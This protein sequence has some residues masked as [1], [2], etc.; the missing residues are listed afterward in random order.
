GPVLIPTLR[1]DDRGEISAVLTA[2]GRAFAHGLTINWPTF[3]PTTTTTTEGTSDAPA[4]TPVDLPTYA[5][6]HQRYWPRFTGLPAGDLGSAGL[7]SAQHPL[8][9][10]A[11]S[12]AGSADGSDGFDGAYGSAEGD[13]V[14][15][16]GR[17]SVAAQPWL[18]EH[19]V[20][21][22]VLLPGTAFLELAVRAGDQVGCA[23]VEE[24]TLQAPLVLP[25]RG[26]VQLQVAVGAADETGRRTLS[27]Y[28]R[29]QDARADQPWVRHAVGV[30]GTDGAAPGAGLSQWPPA[31]AEPVSVEGLYEGLTSAGF[32]YGPLFRG[33]RQVWSRGDELFA[34]VELP[35]RAVPEAA[36][37][38][39]HPA[40]LD[41]VLHALGLVESGRTDED[42]AEAGQGRLPFSWSGATLHASGASVLRARLTVRGPDSVALELADASGA[43]VATIDSLVLRPVS[44]D[45]IAQ[46]KAGGQ[47]TALHTM[48]WIP[49]PEPATTDA[50]TQP[51]I[52]IEA[53]VD[54]CEGAE[55]RPDLS[56]IGA[57]VYPDLASLPQDEVPSHVLLRLDAPD[58]DPAAAAHTATHRALALLQ[59]WLADERFAAARLVVVTEGA[60]TVDERRPDPALAAVWGLVRSARSEHPDRFTLVDLDAASESLATL[61]AALAHDEPELA[62][63]AGQVYVPRLSRHVRPDALPVPELSEAWCLDIAEKGTLANLRLTESPTA[64]AELGVGEVRI[65][66]R[67]AG[68]NFRDVLNALGMYPGDAVALGIEGAGVVTE[69]GPGV[70]GLA[71]GDR[72]MGLFTQSFGPRAVA[73]ARTLARIPEGW[74]FAQAASVPVVFLTAYYALVDLGELQA[75][76]SVLVHAAAGG[77]G[78][79][80]VQLARHLGAEVF[81]TASPG[82]WETLRSSGLDAAHIASSRELDFERSF[83]ETTGGRGVDVVLD[84]L[85]REFVD[86][87]LR[88]LP[89][90]GRF[91]EMGKT[92]VRDPGEVAA[93]HE[94]VRYR[95][96]DLFDAGPERIGEMLTALVALFEQDVLRPLPLTAWDVRKAPEAFRYLS[97]AKNVGKVVLTMP[98][99][100]DAE[101][102]VLV[103]GG[104]GG[105][106][107]LVARHLV[108][109]HGVRHLVLSSRRGPRAPGAAALRD[110]LAALGAEVTVA[111]CDTADREALRELLGSVPRR[112]PLTAIVHTAGVL[113][114]GVLSSLT[115]ERLDAVLVPK[116]DAVSALHEATRG[117]DLAAFVVFSSVAGMFGGSGQGNYSAANAFL[118]AFA[119]ARN[120][121][122]LPATA[123]A[124]GPWA[125]GAGMTGE[126]AEADLRRMARGGMV[127]FTAEQGMAAFDAA[128]R[129]AEA[130]YAP[131]RLD[132]AA[133]RAPQ[134]A[135]PA[136]L[137]ALVTGSARR[138]AASAAAGGA[139]ENLRTGLAALPPA[140]RE[141]AVLELVRAQAALVLGHAGS[142]AVEPAR[143]FRG[144]G[145]DSLTAVELRN[146]LGAATGL[147]LP[148]TLVFDYPSPTALARHVCTE[149]FGDDEAAAT[150]VAVTGRPVTGEEQLA[151]VAMS[152]RFPGGAGSPEEFWRLLADGVDALSPLPDDRG[153]QTGDDAAR[154]EGGFLYD[155]GDFDADFFGISPREAVTMDP[156]QRLLL[157]IS[158]ETLERAGIDP[159]ALRG[160]RTGVFAGTNY[161]GYGSAAH[162]LPEGAEGQLLTGH[163]TSV[164]SGRVSYALGLEGPAVT[165][166]T[167][168][169]SS[170]VALH[171][172]A[173]SL[174]LGECDLAL[175]GGVTVMATP[176]AFV[177]FGRQGGLAGDGRCK[178]FADDADGTGWGE[179]AGI[180]LVERLSDARRNGHPVLA[181]LRG[182][183]VNQDGA[184]N[185]LT[186][187][188]GPSQQRVI[189]AAL[190]N[191]GLDAHEVDAVEAHGTGTSL[192]DP[193]EAQA[194]IA[195]YGQDRAADRPLWLGS[196]KSNIGH[197]QA[198]AGIAGVIKMVLAL[199]K[200]VLPRTLHVTEPSSHVDWS[201]GEVRLLTRAVEWPRCELPRRAAVS[202]FGISGTN[203]HVV[204]EQYGA[205]DDG[206]EGAVERDGAA[207]ADAARAADAGADDPA[208]PVVWPL[209][210]RSG[211]AL[212]DQAKR[213]RAHLTDHPD[214]P[215]RDLGYSLATTRAAF[216]HR[217]ALVAEDR[218]AF[219]KGLAALARG[220]DTAELVRGRADTGGKLAFL[221]SG[222][223]SQRAGM[224]RELHARFPAYAAAFDEACAEFDRHLERPLREIVF[225]DEGTPEA[226]LLD[227][228][229][230]TQPALFAVET[231]LHALVTSWGIRPD[232]LIGHSIGELTAAHVAGVLTLADACRLVAARGRLMQ[233]LPE[234]GAMIAVQAAEEEVRPLLAGLA[235]RAGIAA[236]NGPTAVV[237]SGAQDAVTEIAAQLAERGRKTRRLRVSHAFHSPLM[238]TMLAEFGEIARGVRYAPPRVPVISNLTGEPAADADLTS[239]DYWVRH[240]REAVRF[241]DGVRRLEAD[242]VRTYLELGPDGALAAMA[243]ESLREPGEEAAALPVLRRDR[244]E[245]RSALLA[246]AHLHVR[247]L[248]AGPAALY[249][250]GAR[251]VELPTYAFQR[252]RYWLE[253]AGPQAGDGAAQSLD[254]QFWAAVEHTDPGE[255]AER[256]HLSGDAPL[257]DVL[258]ALSSWR[259]RQR[260]RSAADGWEYRVSWRPA[261]DAPAPVLSGTWLLVHPAGHADHAWEA[262]L[263]AGL[264]AHG[265]AAV[266]PVEV[267]CARADRKS[268]ADQLA[269]LL[270]ESGP[271]D[272]VL[273]LLGTDEEPHR[274]QPATPGGLAA[275]MALV[276]ALD[277]LGTGAPLWCATTGAVAVREGEAVPSPVQAAVWG[278]GRVAALEQPQSWGGLIDLPG[279]PDERAVARLCA[280]LEAGP[281]E[282]QIAVRGSG[283]FAR[284]LVRARTP[285]TA[286]GTD[287]PWA[288]TGTVLITGGTGALGA[289]LARRLADRGAA[290]LILAGRR[291]PQ[292][293]GA[294]ELRDELTARGTRV[295]LAA[296]DAADRDALARLLAEH[297]VDAVFHAAGVL[298]DG[299]LAGLDGDRLDA[300]LRSKMAAAAHLH[301]L[302]DGLSAFVLFS[303]FAGTAGATGQ[304][305]YAAANAYLDALAEHR[306]AL[307]LPATSVAWGPWAGAG[308]AAGGAGDEQLAERLTRGGMNTLDPR[309]A[310]DALERALTRGDTTLTVADV[311]WARFVPGFTSVRPSALLA[312]LPE[313]RRATPERE[314]ADGDGPGGLRALRA[315]LA[316]RSETDQERVLVTLVR[317]QVAG[318]LGY[319]AVDAIDP[320][321]AFSELGFDSLMAVELRNRLGL[322]T[323]TQLPATLLFDHPTAAALA[324]HLRTQVAAGD[325]AGALPALA[326]LDRLEDV[327]A[328]V[329]QDDPQRARI[330]SRLQTLLAK[331]S[332]RAEAD[333]AADDG[334]GVSDRINSA[335]ADEIFD[336]IDN[337]LGMS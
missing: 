134:S 323:G 132:H 52:S 248:G 114:D 227:R 291:G 211:A 271:V 12:L 59:A 55:A 123:L 288:C 196:V 207:P 109:A 206:P 190:A 241:C 228:T 229:A 49:L 264:T 333:T 43:P 152:C 183:A 187:P 23:Q 54:A 263:A 168:C 154:V 176:G 230:Y 232:V 124:W 309:L 112:H 13:A 217:A 65:A 101:G 95:A 141:P 231:A 90:G 94:G 115:P 26:A 169:S 319:D 80:A 279:E 144:L 99:P 200:G 125:P 4:L 249:G 78:M 29:P 198:A 106:G 287:E 335:T 242:G 281:G 327:L 153:W 318:V 102:T 46:A 289:H 91:L 307:G 180:V 310:V 272:G 266:V 40:L 214:L 179:G 88:L 136:L 182:S 235:D 308:M 47:D 131:V 225:A 269:T 218:D 185:G 111:A 159:A 224:G 221:F 270:G 83:L 113:D 8:L 258:P 72:V 155:S 117:E 201:A 158:W 107:A 33:L 265:A 57:T 195:T 164:T 118:D 93:A 301:E 297:P 2:A 138:S 166:D 178:A 298:D 285:D 294:T 104:T 267:D 21:G 246:A 193:I 148:A 53:A 160:S 203:A 194:L 149:L 110:E 11:V 219:L 67:A 37:F 234:G 122:G 306:H 92:D 282:D 197:T 51:P 10:A 76:E 139:A 143:D 276:Q 186:A 7:V 181:V 239:P 247:G 81:G 312:D 216:D 96:F 275:T 245:A 204:L 56:A 20:S 330:A 116:A 14:V 296:C 27:V 184:S 161:Q 244:P 337:D 274:G 3:F 157:E 205:A 325:S 305:N 62:V 262:A 16:T 70:T 150:S 129:T 15:F 126:L 292:A 250:E 39:L 121:V 172:A 226:A 28:S 120:G 286:P 58:G 284:R 66:V 177:E 316:G 259:H 98:V 257:R 50:S 25:E 5:F 240:V 100:L 103:T 213:L 87:S 332:E 174:R 38:G 236:V 173:Q 48:D 42:G 261:G 128:F 322:A 162:T 251:Q 321:R 202:S 69:V 171:L 283:V 336:F 209:S 199:R 237:V 233:A 208:G 82:K 243:W 75:G 163:A 260:E 313:A 268:L 165:V 22:S 334:A 156:Q 9:G 331:W 222:Q 41:S 191:A 89:R 86:A 71:P 303:S 35:E 63:R 295:T 278:L 252:R 189:R 24:L 210:A 329:A 192:G 85:A 74:S 315:Q 45:G 127:P 290:H 60:V 273:S 304:A 324:R 84:S 302:T 280:V 133:L 311:D 142:E 256:L 253:P 145:I 255:L 317:T 61:P 97:Q 223:G 188:N 175:A 326:E 6:Q 130:V 146:R 108:T 79:A 300:V 320:K 254:D 19:C 1:G 328:D 34:S 135:P 36:G 299:L 137:R 18:A 238:D 30:L 140:E 73:D 277:D 314:S 64:Q 293:E 170:L 215:V 31:G 167:A 147:R 77:V 220:E 151:V 212:R 68:L 17:V 44:A 105:L 32:G 119:Q